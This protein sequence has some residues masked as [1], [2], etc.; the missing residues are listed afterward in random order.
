MAARA[1]EPAHRKEVRKSVGRK[2]KPLLN[3]PPLKVE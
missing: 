2:S 1:T 3:K